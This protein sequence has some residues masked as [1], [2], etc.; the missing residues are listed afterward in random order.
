MHE[1]AGKSEKQKLLHRRTTFLIN[2]RL[3]FDQSL[4]GNNSFFY[5]FIFFKEAHAVK[6]QSG[7]RAP[8]EGDVVLTNVDALFEGQRVA[9]SR[10]QFR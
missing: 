4:V 5:L 7:L 9:G 8:Q 6:K 1:I 3:T 2:K 10:Y